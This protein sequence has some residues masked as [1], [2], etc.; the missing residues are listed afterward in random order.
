[1]LNGWLRV[2]LHTYKQGRTHWGVGD[3]QRGSLFVGR[4]RRGR[5][6]LASRARRALVTRCPGG[7]LESMGP[8]RACYSRQMI[9]VGMQSM[10]GA[11]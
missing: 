5:G 1:M 8:L 6:A 3:F 2:V 11:P 10:Q 4:A 7:T 9:S